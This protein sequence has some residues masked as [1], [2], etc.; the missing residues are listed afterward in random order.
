MSGNVPVLDL[1]GWRRSRMPMLPDT[2][3][4][5]PAADWIC[6]I[7]SPSTAQRDRVENIPLYAREG[8]EHCW[9]IDPDL[10]ALEVFRNQDGRWLLLNVL[11][12]DADVRQPPFDAATFALSGLWAG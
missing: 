12:S 7:L 3:W 2:A 8:V 4:F 9:L 11:R 1:A 6:E 5:E 10:R